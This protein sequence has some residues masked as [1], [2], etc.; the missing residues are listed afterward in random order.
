MEYKV[1]ILAAGR[2]DRVSYSKN[3][4]MGLLPVGDKSAISHIIDKFPKEIELVI[5]VGYNASQLKD[6]ID[7]A[8]PTRKITFV[9][10]ENWEG[11]GSGPGLSLLQCKPHLNCPF[12]FTSCDTIVLEDIPEPRRNWI[13]VS[14][15]SDSEN[16]CVAEVKDNRVTKFFD[17]VP[18]P[19]LIKICSDYKTILDHAFIGMA[20][21]HDHEAFW[22]ALE[23]SK[24]HLIKNQLQVSNGLNRLIK[25][26]L[27]ITQFTWFDVGNEVNY[28]YTNRYFDSNKVLAKPDEFIYFEGDSVIKYFADPKKAEGRVKR[29]FILSGLVPEITKHRAN[30]YSYQYV[31]GNMLSK[32][33]SKSKFSDMLNFYKEKIWQKMDLPESQKQ[34]FDEA[35]KQFY[36]DKT[37]QRINDFFEKNGITDE[38]EIINGV[39]VPKL[40]YLL[41][42]I[43]WQSIISGIPVKFHGDFQPENIII[44]EDGDFVLIDWRESF[45]GIR[46]FGDIYYDFSKMQHALII[47]GELMRRNEFEIEKEGN[48]INY[49]FLAKGNLLDFKDILDRFII[50]NGYDLKKVKILT[51]LIYLNIAPLH[52]NPYNL[53][54][55]YLGKSLL[56][57][58]LE[59]KN[60]K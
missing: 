33:L 49:N 24:S 18:T 8:H 48:I 31:E 45:G 38:E 12:I 41:N 30:F 5:P 56:Y 54:L 43:D 14:T 28:Q 52:H 25:K 40:E 1:C 17:K 15:V 47:N 36:I 2:G 21:V 27:E 39:R 59:G 9:D 23:G 4:N 16:F 6:F 11:P 46:E 22:G 60:G 42:K 44:T 29:S 34:Q 32:N 35:C 19:T 57:E 55:F 10:I 3:I 13:G 20:G 58:I 7:M 53:L 50:D 51:S 37:K 26:R